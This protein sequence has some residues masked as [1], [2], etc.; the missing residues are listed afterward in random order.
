MLLHDSRRAART[1]PAG[2][3]VTLEEQDRSA[4][5]RE[6][7]DE[8]RR[9]LE[10][11]ARLRR[12]G[13]YQLQAAIAAVHSAAPTAGDTDWRAIAALY[14]ELVRVDGSP[15]VRLNH[16]VA[17]AM[18]E[19]AERGLEL[20]DAIDDLDDYAPLAVARAELSRRA[21]RPDDAAAAYRRAIELTRSAREREL[22][23]R[24]LGEVER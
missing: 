20:I 14:A 1:G 9:M 3:L 5:D 2:E 19:R 12:P 22:L 10:R 18:S 23:E 4:W 21:G 16:A 8:G 15:V 6:R 13:P 24:R 11:A 7:A 17:V